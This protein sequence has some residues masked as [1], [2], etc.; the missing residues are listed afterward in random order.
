MLMLLVDSL[1][2]NVFCLL[3]NTFFFNLHFYTECVVLKAG[4]HITVIAGILPAIHIHCRR[5]VVALEMKQF[6]MET[7]LY[8]IADGPPMHRPCWEKVELILL[9]STRFTKCRTN[10]TFFYYLLRCTGDKSSFSKQMT[11]N[12]PIKSTIL[13]KN[14]GTTL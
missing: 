8:G 5:I 14:T 9:F 6:F 4:F 11:S 13:A 12:Y 7:L 1:L 10:S 2:M 3:E